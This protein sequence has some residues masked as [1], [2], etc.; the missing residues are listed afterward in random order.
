MAIL[1]NETQV[2]VFPIKVL[3]AFGVRVPHAHSGALRVTILLVTIWLNS[4]ITL[5]YLGL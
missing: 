4:M 2:E 3:V 5:E 1:P